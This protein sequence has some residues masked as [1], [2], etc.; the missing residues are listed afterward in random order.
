VENPSGLRAD[1]LKRQEEAGVAAF[2]VELP[3]ALFAAA[4]TGVPFEPLVDDE[5]SLALFDALL[6]PESDEEP[7]DEVLELLAAA[8]ESVR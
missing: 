4:G 8:R 6:E 2:V 1:V 7:L 3:L 5:L